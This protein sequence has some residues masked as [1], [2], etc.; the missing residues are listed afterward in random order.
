MDYENF[1][2]S[3]KEI[4]PMHKPEAD[5]VWRDFAVESE[6][7]E[8]YVNYE[9]IADKSLAVEKWLDVLYAGF[10]AVK[11]SFGQ[12]LAAAVID[13]GCERS[14]LYPGEMMQA[15]VCLEYGGDAQKIAD[16]IDSGKIDY[17]DIFSPVSQQEARDAMRSMEAERPNSVIAQLKNQPQPGRT[18]TAPKK[19]AEMEI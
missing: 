2:A 12:E 7:L 8:Q 15:A 14:C 16:M 11:E 10:C 4:A 5:P 1:S 6:E 19:G 18:K 13:L 17:P 9:V 3:M